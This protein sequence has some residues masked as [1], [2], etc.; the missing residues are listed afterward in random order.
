MLTSEQIAFY[1]ENGFL[2]IPEV[3]TRAEAD[4]LADEL[5]RLVQDWS[6]TSPGW[7][8]PWRHSL[9]GLL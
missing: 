7:S 5:D 3:F 9:P 8:G 2:H 4:E 1:Q 6:F